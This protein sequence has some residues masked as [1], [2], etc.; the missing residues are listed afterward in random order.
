[1][2]RAH[3]RFL[4]EADVI[5][6]NGVVIKDRDGTEDGDMI[7]VDGVITKDLN[8]ARVGEYVGTWGKDQ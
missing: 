1:M 7:I 8:G 6:E 5:I 3:T 4:A 2:P